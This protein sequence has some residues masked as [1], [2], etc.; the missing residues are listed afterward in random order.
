MTTTLFK[1]LANRS[2]RTDV[3][4]RLLLSLLLLWPAHLAAQSASSPPAASSNSGPLTVEEVLQAS[5][6]QA[7]QIIEAL[8][9]V[10]QAEGRALS[11]EGAFD[12]VFDI[13]AQSRA[14]G[15]YSGSYLEGKATR[16]LTQNGGQIYG[17][18]RVSSGSFPIYED[19]AYTDQLGELKIG[20]LF[21]L[22][23]DRTIDERRGRVAIASRDI[24]AVRLERE[25]VAIGVH[26]ALQP[27]RIDITRRNRHPAAPLRLIRTG[28]RRGCG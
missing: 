8:A 18:Y 12:T 21:A 26:F 6:M 5:A 22:L 17:G 2:E 9:R 23:R 4:R 11:A 7:P 20:G 25:M 28:S 24:D 14:L 16:P 10:R 19:K 13:D 15:F 1:K 27:H 3:I